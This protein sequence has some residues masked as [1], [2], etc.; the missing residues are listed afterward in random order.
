VDREALER[1][2]FVGRL[3]RMF[4][5]N[6]AWVDAAKRMESGARS[7]VCFSHLPGEPWHL[8]RS[9]GE[10]RLLPGA[11]SHPDFVF[12]FTPES[13]ERLAAIDGGI[14]DIAVELFKLIATERSQR[15]IGFRV[16]ASFPT[17]VQRGYLGVLAAGGRRVLAFGASR[18]VRTLA[19]LRRLVERAREA[20]PQDWEFGGP[21]GGY[22]DPKRR[23]SP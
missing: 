21:G 18:G 23:S 22:D 3:A 2:E 17:L 1:D 19:D 15:R 11:A 4:R 6:P 7:T 20:E 9:N 14:G 5:E 10:T 12:R 16:V 8:E 13:I